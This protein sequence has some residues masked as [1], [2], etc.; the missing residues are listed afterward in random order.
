M[1][2]GLEIVLEVL[3]CLSC[4]SRRERLLLALVGDVDNRT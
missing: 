3:R 4:D 2:S 1:T